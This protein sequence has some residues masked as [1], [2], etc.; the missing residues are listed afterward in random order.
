MWFRGWVLW[1][2]LGASLSAQ[3]TSVVFLNP[4]RQDEQFWLGYARFM[5]ASARSLGL[6]LTILYAERDPVRLVENARL[7]LR[8]SQPPDYLLFVNEYYTGPEVLRLSQGT[9]VRLFSVNST[10]TPDQQQLMGGTR[11]RYVNWI[12]SMVP[13]DEEAGYLMASSL[14]RQV[15]TQSNG[16]NEI[17]L[18]AFSGV[19]NTP[20]ATLREQGLQR[21]LRES[22]DVVLRQMVYADW[23]RQRAYEQAMLLLRRYKGVQLIWAAND[24]MAFGAQRAERELQLPGEPLVSALNNSEEV[25]EARENGQIQSLVAGHFTLGGWA[26]VLV[27][28]HAAGY[29]F[30]GR[31]GKDRTVRLFQELDASQARRLRQVLAQ[32]D[33]GVDFRQYSA[34]YQPALKDYRFSLDA[35]LTQPAK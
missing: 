8:G 34:R 35:L 18:L 2:L 22:P 29:D 12:G 7:A 23:N 21:A 33:Y 27:A 25:L 11:E 31:G 32:Q 10:L 9:K 3:A 16:Q 14:I 6:Q 28:D 1:L 24:E 5:E 17:P 4:G 13:N 15:R 26:L 20:A 19:K 30:A